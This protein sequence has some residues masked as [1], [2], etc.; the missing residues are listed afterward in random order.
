MLSQRYR[1]TWTYKNII[2]TVLSYLIILSFST[3]S[4]AQSRP[5]PT[6]DASA[7]SNLLRR[8]IGQSLFESM[9][10]VLDSSTLILHQFTGERVIFAVDPTRRPGEAMESIE[11]R[12]PFTIALNACPN[13]A[14]ARAN[15]VSTFLEFDLTQQQQN[16]PEFLHQ[17]IGAA[18]RRSS[19]PMLARHPTRQGERGLVLEWQNGRASEVIGVIRDRNGLVNIRWSFTD[20]SSCN[21]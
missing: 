14:S 18:Q 16:V 4:Q 21:R 12:S 1:K 9:K 10:S 13:S 15:V 8:Q 3:A 20:D 2:L 17:L 11:Q 6:E 7:W 5:T 19:T